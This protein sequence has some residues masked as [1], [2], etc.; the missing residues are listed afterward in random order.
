MLPRVERRPPQADE[1]NP[2]KVSLPIFHV[3]PRGRRKR[4]CRVPAATASLAG[5][6]GSDRLD[7]GAAD[8]S[9]YLA[10]IS[11]LVLPRMSYFLPILVKASVALSMWENSWPADSC[12]RMRARPLPT[13]G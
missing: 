12:T 7:A 9:P 4:A 5:A 6:S 8:Y 13:T 3:A 10:M 11:S 1:R 2:W